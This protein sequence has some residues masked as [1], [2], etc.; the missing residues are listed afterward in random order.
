MKKTQD[1]RMDDELIAEAVNKARKRSVNP[2]FVTAEVAL[3]CISEAFGNRKQPSDV[4][5]RFMK[6]FV[7][8]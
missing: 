1:L 6:M 5:Q 3:R 8:Q 4:V 7:S 2:N